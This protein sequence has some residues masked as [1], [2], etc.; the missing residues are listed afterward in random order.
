MQV[1]ISLSAYL[2]CPKSTAQVLAIMEKA[3][4]KAAEKHKALEVP[5]SQSPAGP[6]SSKFHATVGGMVEY[7]AFVAVSV[8]MT[9]RTYRH[10]LKLGS[11]IRVDKRQLVLNDVQKV[12]QKLAAGLTVDGGPLHCP[13][14]DVAFGTVHGTNWGGV[15]C[16]A[17]KRSEWGEGQYAENTK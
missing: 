6:D 7:S 5:Q 17:V 10:F 2:V 8:G 3:Y 11:G 13:D 1:Q 9:R 4:K 16:Y 15:G 12:M 14:G